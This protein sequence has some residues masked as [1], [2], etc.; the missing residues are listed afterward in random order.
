MIVAA[1][2]PAYLPSLGYFDRIKQCDTFVF[3][4]SVQFENNSVINRNRIKTAIGPQWLTIPVRHK[5]HLEGTMLT[6]R[7]D[8]TWDWRKKHLR[9]IEQNYRKAPYFEPNFTKIE[10][11]YRDPHDLLA[12]LCWDHLM[13]WLAELRITT[14]IVKLSALPV[15]ARRSDLA[16]DLCRHFGAKRYVSGAGGQGYLEGDAFATAG[17]DVSFQDDKQPAYAQLYGAFAPYMGIV[18]AWMNLGHDAGLL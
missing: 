11:L 2:Q 9:A 1:H 6:T 3:L 18:D 7:I 12:D 8:N 4:D 17:I 13:F 14:R 10:Q 15:V 16:L 5:D